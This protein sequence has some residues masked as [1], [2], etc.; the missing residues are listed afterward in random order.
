MAGDLWFAFKG[1]RMLVRDEEESTNLVGN[2]AALGLDVIFEEEIGVLDGRICF[3]A[4]VEGVEPE[5]SAFQDLRSLFGVLDERCFVMAGRAIQVIAWN[6]M[7]R[8]CG[9]CGRPSR[10]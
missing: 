1:D 7:H 2:P 10:S 8:F 9:R 4:E 5:G 3:A 6:V